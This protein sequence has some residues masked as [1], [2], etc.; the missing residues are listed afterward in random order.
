LELTRVDAGFE[1][2]RRAGAALL[3]EAL[4]G[5]LD[6][7]VLDVSL[8]ERGL[9]PPLVCIAIGADQHLLD[10]LARRWA[11]RGVPHLVGGIEPAYTGII[12]PD[13]RLLEGLSEL[14]STESC[15]LGVS[16]PF[17]GASGL[18]DATRQAR[19]ALETIH[20]GD[21]GLARYGNEGDTFLP[22]TLS[23]ARQAAERVLEPVLDYDREHGTDLIRTLQTYL[24]CDRSPKQTAK[25]LFIHN[26]TVN[27][28]I[29]RVEELT[30][31]TMRSTSDISE[32]WF[33]LRALALS[34]SSALS[35]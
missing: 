24:E 20:Q 3:A 5:R 34:E 17:S 6:D 15:R 31:R 23:E 10:C 29:S 11:V 22:R 35:S 18:I 8:S 16:D 1:R 12:Q 2:E 32:L 26:Q 25:R 9:E 27:Y 14:A 28:R 13:D 30:G 4:H 19:W 7:K 33:G 21:S